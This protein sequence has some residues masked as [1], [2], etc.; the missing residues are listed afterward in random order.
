MMEICYPLI[1]PQL[2]QA[3]VCCMGKYVVQAHFSLD[4][5]SD[6]TPVNMSLVTKCKI[7]VTPFKC[8]IAVTPLH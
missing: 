2:W 7:A 6:N 1:T 4:Q 3:W 5:N 8:K